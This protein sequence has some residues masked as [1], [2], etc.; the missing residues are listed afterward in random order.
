MPRNPPQ[1]LSPPEFLLLKSA[2][3]LLVAVRWL[4][5]HPPLP[6]KLEY[7]NSKV[8]DEIV[9]MFKINV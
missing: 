6:E 7:L 2:A 1:D 4:Q 5:E 9:S 3:K 8:K